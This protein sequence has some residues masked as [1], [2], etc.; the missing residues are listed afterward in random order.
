MPRLVA[1]AGRVENLVALVAK[2]VA[3]AMMAKPVVTAV[4]LET[5]R[6]TAIQLASS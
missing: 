6:R 1:S 5:R 3:V 2:V 4:A